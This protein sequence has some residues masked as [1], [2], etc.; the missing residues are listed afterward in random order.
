MSTK[1]KASCR[2][3]AAAAAGVE[4][5]ESRL[6]LAATLTPRGTLV[7]EGTD[8]NDV[9]VVRRDPQRASKILA[10][11]N[12]DGQKFDANAVKRI[13]IYGGAAGDALTLD[14]ALGVISARGASLFGGGGNDA[15][16]GGL[17]ST[18][19][20]GGPGDDSILG[21][22]K[23]DVIFA[24]R[25]NDTVSGGSGDDFITGGEGVDFLAGYRGDD[26]MYGDQGNDSLFGED[27]R[28]TL[29][30]D[31]EDNFFF[32]GD[33]DPANFAGNDSLDGG[34]GDD[35]LVGGRQSATLND[36]N[37]QDTLTGG[38]GD[39]ILD[40][41]GRVAAGNPNDTITDREAGDVVP[42]E[43]FTR[44]AT[45]GEIAQGEN[46]YQVHDHADMVVQIDDG[47]GTLRQVNIQGGIGDFVGAA[48]TSPRFHVHDGQEGRL[49]MHDLDPATFTLGE[50]FRGWG[51]TINANHIGRYVTG[52]GR[53][54]EFKVVHNGGD[55]PTEILT[56]P[57]NYV[58][59][60]R[61]LFGTGDVITITYS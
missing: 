35:W 13:E 30:G 10:T 46:A 34:D 45:A 9:I 43:N 14:D 12:G 8:G 52:N 41:R 26:Q 25:G 53:K 54:V 23:S 51:V 11:V 59:R 17:A 22:S 19:L 39:D 1:T 47:S 31:N 29:G 60:G 58:M 38:E 27:G 44:V 33:T 15:V 50:F 5:L 28:D 57:Y 7:V 24:G 56:D 42:A 49:H 2:L 18:Y 37:G 4:G 32:Q 6:L 21:S 40:S 20:E 16:T 3:N 48:N 36:N 61:N 55:G